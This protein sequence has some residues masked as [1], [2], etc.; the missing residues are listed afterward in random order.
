[1][2]AAMTFTRATTALPQNAPSMTTPITPSIAMPTLPAHDA[3]TLTEG[4]SLAH[5]ALDGQI[6]TLRITKAGK[7]ILTK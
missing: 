3:R 6:Y 5:I 7:L 4:G 1:M 2:T